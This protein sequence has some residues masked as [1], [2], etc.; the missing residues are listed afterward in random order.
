MRALQEWVASKV[1]G[2]LPERRERGL[3]RMY[4][5][6]AQTAFHNRYW[7]NGGLL[8]GCIREGGPL[9]NDTDADFSFWADDKPYFEEAIQALRSAGFK[10]GRAKPNKDG[11]ITKWAFKSQV[12]KY[13]F[14]Q[15]DRVGDKMCWLSHARKLGLEMTNEVPLHGLSTIELFGRTWL[16]PDDH[17]TYLESLYGNWRVPNPG[18]CYW[19]DSQAVVSRYPW[20]D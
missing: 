4:D 5:V 11:S 19:K 6:L 13:E 2:S 20:K 10:L 1:W 7:M 18:Y 8:L 12:M 16:K 14:Y 15:M 9:K 3:K 17:E